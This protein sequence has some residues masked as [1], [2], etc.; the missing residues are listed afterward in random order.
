[1]SLSLHPFSSA[2]ANDPFFRGSSL[3]RHMDTSKAFSPACDIK[4]DD[5]QITVLANVPGYPKENL[6]LDIDDTG[7]VLTISGDMDSKE[8]RDEENWHVVERRSGSFKRQ[9]RLPSTVDM[10]NI[11]AKVTDGVLTVTVPKKA[12]ES[13]ARSINVQ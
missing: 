9:F 7:R 10:Q 2:F 8:T 13:A 6:K 1:M 11:A 3:M 4:E 12:I 5:K